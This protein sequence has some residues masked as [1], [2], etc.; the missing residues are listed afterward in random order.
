[1][2]TYDSAQLDSVFGALA[3]PK[4]RGIVHVLSLGPATVAQ[5]AGDHDLSLPAIHKHI[6]AL[7]E[8][9]LIV[10][11]KV[12]RTNFGTGVDHAVSHRMGKR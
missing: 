10:R 2:T 9:D 7:E 5:L 3:N 6:R 4:R 8:A 12:G 11:R 1:M